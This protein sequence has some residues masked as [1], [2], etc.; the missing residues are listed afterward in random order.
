MTVH[1]HTHVRTHL[2]IA[3]IAECDHCVT[4]V[5]E[6]HCPETV[7]CGRLRPFRDCPLLFARVAV[8]GDRVDVRVILGFTVQCVQIW[9][10]VVRCT[11]RTRT[12]G[13]H[14][15]TYAAQP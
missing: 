4:V 6:D 7:Y 11:M 13:T 9:S 2:G 8:D 3:L 12:C 15:L 10:I 14:R 1:T 5:I